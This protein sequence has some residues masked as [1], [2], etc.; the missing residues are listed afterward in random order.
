MELF[1]S[2]FIEYFIVRDMPF[3]FMLIKQVLAAVFY[4]CMTFTW[5][6]YHLTSVS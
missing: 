6:G 1:N 4:Y 3:C 2:I 5:I